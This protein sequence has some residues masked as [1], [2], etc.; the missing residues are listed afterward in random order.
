[1]RIFISFPVGKLLKAFDMHR[2]RGKDCARWVRAVYVSLIRSEERL[3]DITAVLSQCSTLRRADCVYSSNFALLSLFVPTASTMRTMNICLDPHDY[4]S[5]SQIV[6]FKNLRDLHISFC[7]GSMLAHGHNTMASLSNVPP[8]SLPELRNLHLIP[9]DDGKHVDLQYLARWSFP[10]L[11]SFTMDHFEKSEAEIKHVASFLDAHPHITCLS[12]KG[13]GEMLPLM[14][15]VRCPELRLSLT[16][17]GEVSRTMV[18][19]LRPEVVRLNL[20]YIDYRAEA[21]WSFLD[22][23]CTQPKGVRRVHIGIDRNCYPRRNID[24]VEQHQSRMNEYASVLGPLGVQLS[25]DTNPWPY[26]GL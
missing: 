2:A 9:S 22:G 3:H 7:P 25:H 12:L 21:L 17:L 16:Q 4:S 26:E 5:I 1:L 11:K 8:W 23:L 15:H 10:K 19:L 20:S 14:S 24:W 6:H 13:L 18:Q